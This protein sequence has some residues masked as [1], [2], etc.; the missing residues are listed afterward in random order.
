M[1][2]HVNKY[3]DRSQSSEG[4]KDAARREA[5][6]DVSD[7]THTL[8]RSGL[9]AHKEVITTSEELTLYLL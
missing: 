7:V 1:I 8:N 2:E 6:Y 3:E 4:K 5:G 9:L